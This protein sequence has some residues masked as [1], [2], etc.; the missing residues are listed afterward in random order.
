MNQRIVKKPDST[1]ELFG[2]NVPATQT[3]NDISRWLEHCA[4]QR[5]LSPHT[6][7]GY[8]R[9]LA[10]LE[11]WMEQ[12][13]IGA[14]GELSPDLMRSFMADQHRGGLSAKS[15]QRLL[16]ACRGLFAW[17]A[18]QGH[19]ASDPAAGVRAP[20]VRRKLPETLDADEARLLVELR[21]QGPLLT[22]DRAMLEL[23]YSSG[24]RLSE[25]VGLDWG[26]LDLD[27]GE[28]R[29][30][31]KGSKTRVV[32]VGGKA[33]EA[34]RAL[35]AEQGSGAGEPVFRGR[36]GKHLSPRA[37]QL[38][39]KHAAR[40]QNLA[41]RV[42]PHLLRHSCASH[43]LES[44][45]DLRAVQE[46]LGHADIGTTEIYTHLDFQHLAKVYDAAHPRAKRKS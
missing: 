39:V 24:L 10:R 14:I 8:R 5:R 28:V 30:T 1:V 37:A 45:S 4:S 15:L 12:H 36:H 19:L 34:L 27:V 40:V 44:S 17:L 32:P 42:Y 25:L 38:R 16:S 2:S 35:A 31:G 26:E 21:E 43:L 3:P 33:I 46:L 13:G 20:K 9:D 22:R 23:F 7:A 11:A 41:K 18:R 6:V 29:V